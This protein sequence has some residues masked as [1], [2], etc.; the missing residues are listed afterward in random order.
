MYMYTWISTGPVIA[1]LG[2]G[3]VE[4][5]VCRGWYILCSCITNSVVVIVTK[6]PVAMY[7]EKVKGLV[8]VIHINLQI[9]CIVTRVLLDALVRQA[10]LSN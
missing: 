6:Q 10:I 2:S 9:K 7:F 3:C 1:E 5:T 8:E 4:G